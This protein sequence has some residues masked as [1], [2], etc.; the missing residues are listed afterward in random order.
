[1]YISSLVCLGISKTKKYLKKGVVPTQK[2]PIV[3]HPSRESAP[4][5][6]ELRAKRAERRQKQN[7]LKNFGESCKSCK[8]ASKVSG[9]QG[10]P[11]V[12]IVAAQEDFAEVE[13]AAA[14][15]LLEP[16]G[17][18]G[19]A[20]QDQE[21]GMQNQSTKVDKAVQF[22]ENL[23]KTRKYHSVL[24]LIRNDKDLNTLTGLPHMASLDALV[25]CIEKL[26][27]ERFSMPLKERI[28]LTMM[29]LKLDMSFRSLSVF[30]QCSATTS[31]NYFHDVIR[32]LSRVLSVMIRWPD[33]EEIMRNMPHCFN[34][35]K[36]T[37]VVLDCTEV[38][39]EK[40]NR[41]KCLL[42][43]ILKGGTL[44]NF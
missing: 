17:M 27:I 9:I 11:L 12:N 21:P 44:S 13:M 28:V 7:Q 5:T 25:R 23:F 34:K 10:E 14:E 38:P 15:A 6:K 18:A 33:K 20:S 19:K 35:Y 3:S 41:L 2:L 40:T 39:T 31:Q 8:C 4:L 43:R 22:D 26:E 24:E 32:K 42:T 37:R 16:N 1:M 30:F 29:K 36:N